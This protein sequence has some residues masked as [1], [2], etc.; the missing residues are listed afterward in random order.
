MDVRDLP[1]VDKVCA[2]QDAVFDRNT[3]DSI[4]SSQ[5]LEHLNKADQEKALRKSWWWLKPGC[6]IEIWTP[7]LERQLQ[8]YQEG[9]ITLQWL[10]TVLY[11]E[12]DYPA[13][14]H[15]WVHTEESLRN[16]LTD[17]GFIILQCDETE[18]SLHVVARKKTLSEMKEEK[19]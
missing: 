6:V 12:Q 8:W 1:G 10:Q 9:K 19:D 2:W 17:C 14:T 5:T 3:I 7:C 16:I 15:L 4:F 18:G 13:N 11:G